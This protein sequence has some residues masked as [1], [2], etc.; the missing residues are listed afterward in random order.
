M[1]ALDFASSSARVAATATVLSVTGAPLH[2]SLHLNLTAMH[3]LDAALPTSL[4]LSNAIYAVEYIYNERSLVPERIGPAH[5]A[6]NFRTLVDFLHEG[7]SGHGEPRG[8]PSQAHRL[9]SVGEAL[10]M[11]YLAAFPS[12]SKLD[13]EDAR[14]NSLYRNRMLTASLATWYMLPLALSL[15]L[16]ARRV[17]A[18]MREIRLLSHGELTFAVLAHREHTTDRPLCWRCGCRC[19]CCRPGERWRLTYEFIED[20]TLEA[21]EEAAELCRSKGG[22]SGGAA[23]AAAMAATATGG[24]GG[25][26][27]R[28]VRSG[29]HSNADRSDHRGHRDHDVGTRRSE[30]RDRLAVAWAL[31]Q[32]SGGGGA[33]SWWQPAVYS[34]TLTVEDAATLRRVTDEESEPVLY[35]PSEPSTSLLLDSLPVNVRVDPATGSFVSSR[36]VP[37]LVPPAIMVVGLVVSLALQPS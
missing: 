35:L 18:G 9:P 27:D 8:L 11:H 10:P 4:D 14:G 36:W 2:W 37:G 7:E 5:T 13:G 34:V 30:W 19:G 31:L 23:A 22:G 20:G 12:I 1:T 15:L 28:G 32:G 6:T 25:G 29:G 16:V 21:A 24:R 33:P 26:G 3:A 17:K